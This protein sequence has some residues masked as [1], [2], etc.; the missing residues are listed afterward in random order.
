LSRFWGRFLAS[1]ENKKCGKSQRC[2]KGQGLY[3][4]GYLQSIAMFTEKYT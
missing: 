3:A 1:A 4:H 2:R